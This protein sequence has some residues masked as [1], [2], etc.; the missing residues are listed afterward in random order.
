MD[1]EQSGEPVQRHGNERSEADPEQQGRVQRDCQCA[2]AHIGDTQQVL[3]SQ[4]F[5]SLV[6][7]A[8]GESKPY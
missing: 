7:T 8:A 4:A 5:G 1:R 2:S 3:R 6:E